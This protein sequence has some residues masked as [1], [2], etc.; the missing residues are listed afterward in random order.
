[1][2]IVLVVGFE[3]TRKPTDGFKF[4]VR[5]HQLRRPAWLPVYI[6]LIKLATPVRIKLT[7]SRSK[8]NP[9]SLS[10]R[11]NNLVRLRG[12]EPPRSCDH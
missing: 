12:I 1:M 2:H 4:P 6:I 10:V 8:R 9:L 3:P 11:G 7:P 5:M